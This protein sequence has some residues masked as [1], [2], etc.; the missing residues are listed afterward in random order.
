MEY[1][2]VGAGKKRKFLEAVLPSMLD[3]LKL[4]SSS[5]SLVISLE[6]DC[7]SLGLTVDI[8]GIGYMVVINPKQ[9]FKDLALTLA[10]ELVHVRQM[11]KGIMFE[12]GEGYKLWSGKVY[13]PETPYLDQ[14]WEC[15]AF[16]NQEL[17]MRRAIKA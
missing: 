6:S 12:L 5:K 13:G 3:Q 14:P 2:V 15:D 4:A 10:H 7:K 11:A 17:I 1:K 8:A 16:A 9:S